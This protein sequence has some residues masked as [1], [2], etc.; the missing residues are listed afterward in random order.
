MVQWGDVDAADQ[1]GIILSYT[2]T[3][4]ALPSGSEQTKEV[5]APITQ[6][7][8]TGL[9]KYTNYRITVSAST[10]K[11][12]GNASASIIVITDEDS[13]LQYTSCNFTIYHLISEVGPKSYSLKLCR[14][15]HVSRKFVN[16]SFP[17]VP[18]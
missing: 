6:A 13:K 8:L 18:M 14:C 12:G 15:N 5:D 1:N 4:R 10:S 16:Y 7:N 2:V 9:N 17:G 3:Y 11:G